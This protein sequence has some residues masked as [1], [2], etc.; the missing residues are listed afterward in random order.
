MAKYAVL[1]GNTVVNLIMA[2]TLEI[3]EAVSNSTC[4]ECEIIDVELGFTYNP[5]TNTFTD[6]EI[7]E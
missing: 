5:D 2:D 6:P 4:V 1:N 7:V 3:A